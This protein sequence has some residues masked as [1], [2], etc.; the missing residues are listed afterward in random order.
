MP[1]Y[2]NLVVE[3]DGPI[4]ILTVSR[5]R[6]L[7][8]LNGDTLDELEVAFSDLGEDARVGAVVVT[9]AGEKAFVA[10]ADVAELAGLDAVAAEAHAR[11]GQRVLGILAEM[12]KPTIAAV[13]G[14]ALGG[15]LE[16]ALAC[17]VRVAAENAILGLPEVSLGVIPGFGGTQRLP[18]LVGVGRAMEL[19]LTGRKIPAAEAERMG[20]VNR[21][22][23]REKLIEE[24][25]ALARE[26]LANGPV[27]LRLAKE[28]VARGIETDLATGL[29]F[30]EKAFG[31]AFAT[32]DMK[33]GTRAFL[34]KRKPAFTGRQR[35]QSA[36]RSEARTPER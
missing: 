16:L 36:E 25:K 17:D 29:A 21:V 12:G 15:G 23:A 3:K 24:A 6:A 35:A 1:G 26:M 2:Q 5:P 34:E 18:R 11:R 9:G 7:N 4:A 8:A 30:E 20:L 33:E 31:V 28:C 13:N 10:G 14:Y 27:A 22:V 19:V 32:S